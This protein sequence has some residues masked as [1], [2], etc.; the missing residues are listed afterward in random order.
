MGA[1][2]TKLQGRLGQIETELSHLVEQA[3]SNNTRQDELWK[4]AYEIFD[5][6]DGVGVSARYLFSDGMVL[7]RVMSKHPQD[8]A[9]DLAAFEKALTPEQWKACSR[10]VRLFDEERTE[11][12][13][14]KDKRIQDAIVA[15]TVIKPKVPR[16]HFRPAPAEEREE[17]ERDNRIIR[18][19]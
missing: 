3:K 14:K 10:I 6:L 7:G 5:Q 9:L 19:A 8:G 18:I 1:R 15:C 17:L 2:E 16:K 13:A 12:A 4:E 11:K